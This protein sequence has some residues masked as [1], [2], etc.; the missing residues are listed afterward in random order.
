MTTN[1]LLPGD[2]IPDDLLDLVQIRHRFLVFP[3][4]EGVVRGDYPERVRYRPI[5]FELAFARE[6]T[7][8]S[9]IGGQPGWIGGDDEFPG[10]YMGQPLIFLM[11]W[12][13]EFQFKLTADAPPPYGELPEFQDTR[14][15]LLCLGNQVYFFGND[16]DGK[17]NIYLCDQ[18][19]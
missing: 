11:Q 13:G 3:T 9:K 2:D 1:S 17:S 18:R 16:T 10:K 7:T 6:S 4:A 8:K 19:V 12:R 14:E 15:Y 5:S